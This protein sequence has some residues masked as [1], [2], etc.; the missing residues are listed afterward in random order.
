MMKKGFTLI[1]TIIAISILAVVSSISY[2]W[3]NSSSRLFEKESGQIYNRNEAR[4]LIEEIAKEIQES[5]LEE[6]T[7]EEE[8]N[9][10]IKN[11]NYYLDENNKI[12]T[13]NFRR[14]NSIYQ[15]C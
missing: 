15:R 1:E 11:R 5:S 8:K 13:R 12:C 10:Y 9:L 2:T 7:I 6:I 3:L 4:R 14:E